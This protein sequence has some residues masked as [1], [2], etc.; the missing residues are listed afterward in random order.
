MKKKYGVLGCLMFLPPLLSLRAVYINSLRAGIIAVISIFLVVKIVPFCHKRESIWLFIV[1]AYSFLP[2]N[3]VL[4]GQII[5]NLGE[6]ISEMI[7]WLRYVEY[8]LILASIEE[9]L[10]GF[11]GRLLWRRQYKLDIS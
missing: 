6:K 1:C 11:I 7:Y 2:I 9:V 10:M 3:F 8:I 5:M 4:A